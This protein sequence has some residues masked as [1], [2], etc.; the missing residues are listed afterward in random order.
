MVSRTRAGLRRGEFAP[1]RAAAARAANTRP[2]R[3]G[4]FAAGEF[5]TARIGAGRIVN[6]GLEEEGNSSVGAF[7]ANQFDEAA[8]LVIGGRE[9]VWRPGEKDF[10][11]MS[12]EFAEARGREIGQ[13]REHAVRAR[14]IEAVGFVG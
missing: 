14:I 13:E 1:R 4:E 7:V 3:E 2:G 6:H 9:V 5:R 12:A 11:A 10:D 8:L